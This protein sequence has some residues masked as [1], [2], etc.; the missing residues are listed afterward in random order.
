MLSIPQEKLPEGR[1]ASAKNR[2]RGRVPEMHPKGETG[3]K[4]VSKFGYSIMSSLSGERHRPQGAMLRGP[5]AA[6]RVQAGEEVRE[7][8]GQKVH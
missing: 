2:S 8:A 3:S 1:E 4:H 6:L 5:R 7:E